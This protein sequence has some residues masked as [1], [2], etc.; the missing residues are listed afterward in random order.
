MTTSP[1]HDPAALQ[2][3]IDALTTADATKAG[4]LTGILTHLASLDATTLSADACALGTQVVNLIAPRTAP[5]A[6]GTATI[7]GLCPDADCARAG[8]RTYECCVAEDCSCS[9]ADC[10]VKVNDSGLTA[11]DCWCRDHEVEFTR[12]T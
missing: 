3:R 1:T 5:A 2:A 8:H 4:I 11:E 6:P 9:N 7:G 10:S 12:A